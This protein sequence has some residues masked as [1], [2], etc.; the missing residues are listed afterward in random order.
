MRT[1]TLFTNGSNQAVR[2]PK[3]MEFVGINEL[4]IHREGDVLILRPVRPDWLSYS[5]VEKADTDW[6]QERP[7]I[8]SDE[9]RFAWL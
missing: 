6:L 8:I 3:D 5:E 7:D 1:V 2:I 9:G 4:E